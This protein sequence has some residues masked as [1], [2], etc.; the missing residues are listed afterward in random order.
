MLAPRSPALTSAADEFFKGAAAFVSQAQA[1]VQCLKRTGSPELDVI[2]RGQGEKRGG[3]DATRRERAAIT[4]TRVSRELSSVPPTGIGVAQLGDEDLA[5]A[6]APR[7]VALIDR[8]WTPLS[9]WHTTDEVAALLNIERSYTYEYAAAFGGRRLSDSPKAR[10][11]FRLVDVEAA[12]PCLSS[13]GSEERVTRT[14]KP[15]PRRRSTARSGTGVPL[16]P[17]R[18]GRGPS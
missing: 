2:R 16:L 15:K 13:R 12:L 4:H 11:R 7:V 3:H 5:E 1:L 17:I 9:A 14:A 6:V 8:R 18:G 10:L